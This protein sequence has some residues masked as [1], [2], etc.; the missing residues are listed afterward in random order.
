MPL[1]PW[2]LWRVDSGNAPD[3]A[4]FP[5]PGLM[6]DFAE[7]GHNGSPHCLYGP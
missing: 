5:Q 2:F 3:I 4:L 1:P 7:A 6:L